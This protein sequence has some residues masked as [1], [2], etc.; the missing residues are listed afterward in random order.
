MRSARPPPSLWELYTKAL[1]TFEGLGFRREAVTISSPS[2]S[3]SES[4]IPYVLYILFIFYIVYVVSER[5]RRR[6]DATLHSSVI[7]K[8]EED[9]HWPLFSSSLSVRDECRM[10]SLLLPL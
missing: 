5:R 7:E 10:A 4:D 2:L 8:E 3:R 6:R 9:A 1:D